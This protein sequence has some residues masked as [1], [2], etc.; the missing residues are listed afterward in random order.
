MKLKPQIPQMAQ[1]LPA[2]LNLRESAESAVK[3]PKVSH[4]QAN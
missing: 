4:A 2:A 3:T 1:I